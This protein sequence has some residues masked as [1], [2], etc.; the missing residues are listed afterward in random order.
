[1][2]GENVTS[3][4]PSFSAS[5]ANTQHSLHPRYGGGGGG[6]ARRAVVP[7]FWQIQKNGVHFLREAREAV[8][9]SVL[10]KARHVLRQALRITRHEMA[11]KHTA[12]STQQVVATYVPLEFRASELASVLMELERVNMACRRNAPDQAVR[13]AAASGSRFCGGSA[14]WTR[15]C[16]GLKRLVKNLRLSFPGRARGEE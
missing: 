8:G 12:N 9:V 4:P 7:R 2:Q 10:V 15:Q 11:G 16:R 3:L 13:H 1:M 6:G 5:F 14:L